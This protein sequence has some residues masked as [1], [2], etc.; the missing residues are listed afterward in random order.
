M[1][2][3][4][5][6]ARIEGPDP[7]LL[8]TKASLVCSGGLSRAGS[9]AGDGVSTGTGGICASPPAEQSAQGSVMSSKAALQVLTH[10]IR[11]EGP[12]WG[13]ELIP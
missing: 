11:R 6:E 9:L 13:G 12:S 8:P 4:S 10:K 1:F 5:S 2:S 3:S 7:A